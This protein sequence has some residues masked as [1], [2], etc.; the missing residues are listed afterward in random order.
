MRV[1]I[2]SLNDGST[3]VVL[4]SLSK[5]EELPVLWGFDQECVVGTM[6][7]PELSSG[8]LTAEYTITA[9]PTLYVHYP[10][11]F[12]MGFKCDTDREGKYTNIEPKCVGWI[13]DDLH[14]D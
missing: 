10:L 12:G 3:D 9:D 13:R 5:F 14:S 1:I 8:V 4:E 6:T 7:N 2:A 11:L